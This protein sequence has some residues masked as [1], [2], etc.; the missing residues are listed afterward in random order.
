MLSIFF[1][2][3]ERQAIRN[4]RS[5]VIV[6]ATLRK[7]TDLGKEVCLCVC[8]DHKEDMCHMTLCVCVVKIYED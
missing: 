3:A 7:H 2:L 1:R 6:K 8:V 4:K 5:G